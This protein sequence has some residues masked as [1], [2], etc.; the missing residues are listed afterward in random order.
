MSAPDKQKPPPVLCPQC[1]RG[2]LYHSGS[3]FDGRPEFSCTY[4]RRVVTCGH[5]GGE[6]AHLV[7]R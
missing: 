1:R 6:Y 3:A 4:C 2:R 7:L 5:D